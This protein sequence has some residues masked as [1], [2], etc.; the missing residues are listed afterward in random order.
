M[1]LP[2][3]RCPVCDKTTLPRGV[4]QDLVE[5]A[6]STLYAQGVTDSR[7]IEECLRVMIDLCK[8]RGGSSPNE[9]A[10]A[11]NELQKPRGGRG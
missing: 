6:V 5:G 4:G 9:I 11:I 10:D 7:V 3:N 1:T 8:A 2:K